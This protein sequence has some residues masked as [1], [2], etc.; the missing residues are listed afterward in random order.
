MLHVKD[1]LG[2]N[3]SMTQPEG[4]SASQ[5]DMWRLMINKVRAAAA[6]HAAAAMFSIKSLFEQFYL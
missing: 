4:G 2:Q 3:V 5:L 1:A 6:S